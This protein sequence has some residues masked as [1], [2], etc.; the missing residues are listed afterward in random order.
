MPSICEVTIIG[1][2]GRDPEV[3][4]GASSVSYATF[5]VATSD[6][7]KSKTGELVKN[8]TWFRV[9]CFGSSAKYVT[10]YLAKGSL[11]FV[12][13]RLRCVTFLGKD[14]VERQQLEITAGSVT[15][16]PSAS[17]A[18]DQKQDLSPVTRNKALATQSGASE[19][20]VMS[21][22]DLDDEIPF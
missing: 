15:A 5:S 20:V 2:L 18:K 14:K 17:N 13:G 8:T 16:L 21:L 4:T 6:T 22:D 7:R 9:V 1:H 11:V 19:R 12:S 3:A 10:D